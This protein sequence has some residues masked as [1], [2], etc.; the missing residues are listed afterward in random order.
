MSDLSVRRLTGGFGLAIV[1][2]NWAMFPLYVI[3]GPAPQY[4]DTARFIAYW[5][6]ING[7]VM[8]RVLLDIFECACLIVFAAGLR[9]LIRQ[10]RS[11][12]E[13]IGTLAFGSAL[14]LS[15]VTLV[16]ASLEGGAA[17]DAINGPA[18][19]SA[20]RA[21]SEGYILIYQSIGCILIALFSASVGY[22]TMATGVLPRWT[23]WIAYVA[24]ILNL[25]AVPIGLSIAPI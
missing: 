24:A 8:T 1:A 12:Y 5:N 17:L 15:T 14:A 23:G 19:P 22:A 4:Q 18:D 20:I 6:S 7:L 25:V 10:A 11:D 13:W 21:L 16:A 9:H 2:L 3:P